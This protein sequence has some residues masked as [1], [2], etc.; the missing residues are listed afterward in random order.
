MNAMPD[1]HD[2]AHD[3]FDHLLES[4][5][6]TRHPP[7]PDIAVTVSQPVSAAT[8]TSLTERAARDGRDVADIVADALRAAAA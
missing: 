7:N 1:A 6:A 5:G 4:T 8:L 3:A 2:H